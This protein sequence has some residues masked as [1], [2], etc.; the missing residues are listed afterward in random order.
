MIDRG[1][2]H[3]ALCR[4]QLLDAGR[5]RRVDRRWQLDSTGVDRGLPLVVDAPQHAVVDEQA[6]QLAK[7]Q[8]ISFAGVDGP[9]EHPGRDRVGR[10]QVECHALRGVRVERAEED[11]EIGR[12]PDLD[13]RRAS[14]AKLGPRQSED[15]QRAACPLCE[16]LD[17]IEQRRLSPVHV[18]YQQHDRRVLGQRLDEPAQRPEHLLG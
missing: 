5:E 18:V 1:F 7:E 10:E 11:D 8:R 15:E 3:G 16:V 9:R 17:Q 13:K 12:A 4:P 2:E 6:Q 14:L